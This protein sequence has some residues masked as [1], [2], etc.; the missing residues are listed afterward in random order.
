MVQLLLINENYSRKIFIL[1][2]I[3]TIGTG[4]VTCTA[5]NISARF[6][7]LCF[8]KQPFINRPKHKFVTQKTLELLLRFGLRIAQ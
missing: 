6:T 3:A 7:L 1:N 5:T 2:Y 8:S 4:C